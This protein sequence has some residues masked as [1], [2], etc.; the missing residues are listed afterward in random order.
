MTFK[1]SE[2]IKSYRK[3]KTRIRIATLPKSGTHF[4]KTLLDNLGIRKSRITHVLDQL[5]VPTLRDDERAVTTI[6]DPRAFFVS[7]A[8]WC[9]IRCDQILT[10]T[11]PFGEPI[12]MK[13]NQAEEWVA[14]TLDDK[15]QFL[16][17]N[18]K[19]ALYYTW[20]IRWFFECTSRFIK[21]PNMF[22]LKFEDMMRSDADGPTEVQL[23]CLQGMFAHFRLYLS[24]DELDQ[25]VRASQGKSKTFFRGK[26]DAWRDELSPQNEALIEENWGQFIDQ[27]RYR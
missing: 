26:P 4:L 5:E 11:V 1:L 12:D 21:L 25:A 19:R 23:K 27:W 16:V 3:R 10:D 22:V 20:R 9:D 7:L 24:L 13:Y 6:R 17:T 15:I 2:P 14:Y 8:H 18:D